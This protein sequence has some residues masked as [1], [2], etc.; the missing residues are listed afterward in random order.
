MR[1]IHWCWLGLQVATRCCY[2]YGDRTRNDTSTTF[3][4]S[5]SYAL[6]AISPLEVVISMYKEP[7][8]DVSN[9][10]T[11]LDSAL[12]TSQAFVTIHVKDAKA[13]L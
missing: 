11:S 5:L 10:V 1:V 7:V 12:Q 8:E 3:M 2:Q 9:L 4:L 6:V 13:I